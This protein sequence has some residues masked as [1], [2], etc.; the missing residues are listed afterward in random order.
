MNIGEFIIKIGTQGDTKE[1]DKAIKKLAEAEKKTRRQ[2]KLMR[3]LAKA[4][5]EEEKELIKKNAA[6]QEEIEGFKAAK[7]ENDALTSSMQKGMSTALKMV[8]A[9]S[10][11]VIALDRMGNSL[12]KSNQAYVTFNAATDISIGRLTK[13]VGLAKLTNMNMT[14]EQVA[15]DIEALQSKIFN[16]ERFGKE[17]QTFGMLNI[18]PRGMRADQVIL[19]LRKSLQGYSGQIKSQYLSQLGL[20]QEWLTVLNLTNKEFAEYLDTANKLQL[21]EEERKQL[22]KYTAAQQK[23]NMRWELARQKLLIAVMPMVQKIMDAMSKAALWISDIL[24]KNPPWLTILRD[25]LIMFTGAKILSTIKAINEMTKTLKE[26]GIVGLLTGGAKAGTKTAAKAGAGGLL[27][28]F[29]FKGLSKIFGKTA[30]KAGARIAA[31]QGVA[32]GAGAASGG[33]GYAIVNTALGVWALYDIVSALWSWWQNKEN[34][35]E[36]NLTPDPDSQSTRYAYHNVN[37]NMTNNFFNNP[38]PARE[39]ISQLYNV[40]ALLLAEQNR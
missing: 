30:A 21:T 19:M 1:L 29:G 12:L 36:E 18:N 13:M 15:S 32:A 37:A 39:A 11:A 28:F 31:G 3:D 5:S 38:V 16:L 35:E 40:Q 34:E 10:G 7:E 14:A 4:T 9:I 2:I 24:E 26:L 22:A 25:I 8:A 23:N 20:S 27:G 33:A 6:Q 17:A